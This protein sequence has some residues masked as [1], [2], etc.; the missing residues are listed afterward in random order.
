MSRTFVLNGVDVTNLEWIKSEFSPL[1][2]ATP[3]E[4]LNQM[5]ENAIRY[6]NTNSAYRVSMLVDYHSDMKRI[7]ISNE[8]KSVC[9]VY[10]TKVQS[11]VWNDH[12]LWTLTGIAI[13]DCVT[14]DLILTSEAFKTFRQYVGSNFDWRYERSTDSSLGGYLYVMNLPASSQGLVVVGTKRILHDE[15]I[16]DDHISDW[17]LRYYKALVKQV[18]GNTL[19]KVGIINVPNDGNDLFTEGMNEQKDL[20]E[21]LARNGRWCVFIARK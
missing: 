4:T 14:T 15:E 11:Y 6:W 2:L 10:P 20:K 12:P 16:K 8:I 13:I 1:T 18:E 17:I 19:R 7:Q 9:A 3:D 5:C 21:E